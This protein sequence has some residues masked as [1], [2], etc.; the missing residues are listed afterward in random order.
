MNVYGC[1]ESGLNHRPNGARGAESMACCSLSVAAL[2]LAG[3]GT[4]VRLYRMMV[5][6][7]NRTVLRGARSASFQ[8]RG[9]RVETALMLIGAYT[10]PFTRIVGINAFS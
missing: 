4:G 8:A 10:V 2:P 5:L 9:R 6:R 3:F 7:P 1:T